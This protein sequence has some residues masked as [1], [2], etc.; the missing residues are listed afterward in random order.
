[1]IQT[2]VII[3]INFISASI[4]INNISVSI[5]LNDNSAFTTLNNNSVIIH[6]N[7]HL[8][9]VHLNNNSAI[10]YINNNSAF[11]TLSNSSVTVHL[12]NNSSTIYL[13]V[14]SAIIFIN[15]DETISDTDTQSSILSITTLKLSD[16]LISFCVFYSSQ[17]NLNSELLSMYSHNNHHFSSEDALSILNSVKDILISLNVVYRE[18]FLFIN[19][20]NMSQLK[21]L[22]NRILN[23]AANLILKNSSVKSFITDSEEI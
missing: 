1:M 20:A 22:K 17:L 19:S 2:E 8:S 10:T 9:T 23:Y 5:H 4:L 13:I 6:L 18:S 7:K 12:N 14:N 11:T 3:F 16:D 15:N 21:D